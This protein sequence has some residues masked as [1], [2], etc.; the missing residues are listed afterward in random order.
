MAEEFLF[1]DYFSD[2][3]DK[4]IEI[5]VRFR[6]KVLPF[7]IKHSL[8]LGEKQKAMN[9]ALSVSIDASGKPSIDNMNQ[10][11]YTE[12]IVAAALLSWPFT[13]DGKPL[14]LTR[15]NIHALDGTLSE[16]IA[17]IAL[18]VEQSQESAAVPFGTK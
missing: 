17:N 5:H 2:P 6:G 8:S 13:K 15:A 12:E 1:D 9:A 4:G 14:P 3:N 18:G 10:G 11:A 7:R 16:K